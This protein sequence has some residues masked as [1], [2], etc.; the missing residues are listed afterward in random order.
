MIRA[1]LRKH[2]GDVVKIWVRQSRDDRSGDR[3][4][5]LSAPG[6]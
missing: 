3:S 4:V 2:Q 6:P 1:I 5:V